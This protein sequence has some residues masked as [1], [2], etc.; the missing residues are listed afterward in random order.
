MEGGYG[1]KVGL[2]W[3]NV[4]GG[5][6]AVVA[7]GTWCARKELQPVESTSGVVGGVDQ[8]SEGVAYLQK[9]SVGWCVGECRHWG[10]GILHNGVMLEILD[11]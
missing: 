11:E 8:V 3:W 6:N 5:V 2:L 7:R 1:E 4:K 9:K 10:D